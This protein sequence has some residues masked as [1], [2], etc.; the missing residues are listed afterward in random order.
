M[1]KYLVTLPFRL[2]ISAIA[3]IIGII[4]FVVE[5][6]TTEQW[7]KFLGF[8]FV[9]L[10]FLY[11]AATYFEG[12]QFY[13]PNPDPYLIIY[14]LLGVA[15]FYLLVSAVHFIFKQLRTVSFFSAKRVL[16]MPKPPPPSLEPIPQVAPTPMVQDQMPVTPQEFQPVTAPLQNAEPVSVASRGI[17]DPQSLDEIANALPPH[18]RVLV[19]VPEKK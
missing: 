14:V 18:L 15:A 6:F 16:A 13:D 12:G 7:R 9:L 1:I 8:S 17:A 19:G 4:A 2:V 5:F 11:V 3:A 10:G